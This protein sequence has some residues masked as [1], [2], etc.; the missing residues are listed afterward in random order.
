MK[1]Q[2]IINAKIVLATLKIQ[3][4]YP[5][6]K[7]NLDEIPT[8]FVPKKDYEIKTKDLKDYLNSL[9]EILKTYAKKHREKAN[10]EN[11]I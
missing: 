9:N 4:K 8:H 3:E 6:L 10:Y 1:S 7:K 5:E 2:E 11:S